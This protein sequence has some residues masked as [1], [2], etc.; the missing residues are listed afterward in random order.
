MTILEKYEPPKNLK[1]FNKEIKKL[2]SEIEINLLD[3]FM[4]YQQGNVLIDNSDYIYGFAPSIIFTGASKAFLSKVYING[5]RELTPPSSGSDIIEF[6]IILN[7]V[8]ETPA[9]QI[10]LNDN[11]ATNIAAITASGSIKVSASGDRFENSDITKQL[12]LSFYQKDFLIL[13]RCLGL[14]SPDSAQS[15]QTIIYSISSFDGLF[16][17]TF[18]FNLGVDA[19]ICQMSCGFASE[20]QGHDF[21]DVKQIPISMV[22]QN[23][24]TVG[25]GFGDPLVIVNGNEVPIGQ[26]ENLNEIKYIRIKFNEPTTNEPLAF[27]NTLNVGFLFKSE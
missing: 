20:I 5:N 21:S 27:S 24:F 12:Q 4:T 18:N 6:F 16:P 26:L 8:L 10:N 23:A 3:N 25:T 19:Q 22:V 7:G 17:D 9:V 14:D 11:E 13:S 15:D 2:D 1:L